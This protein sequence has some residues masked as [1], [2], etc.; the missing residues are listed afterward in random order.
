[1]SEQS[2]RTMPTMNYDDLKHEKEMMD[3]FQRELDNLMSCLGFDVTENRA[4]C[5]MIVGWDF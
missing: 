2:E 3:A 1:M 4:E 5:A